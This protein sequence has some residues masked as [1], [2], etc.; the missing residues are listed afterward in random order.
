MISD[1][2]TYL[3]SCYLQ[4]RLFASLLAC[5]YVFLFCWIIA[6]HGY[7][8][9]S[10]FL[11]F[12]V[13]FEDHFVMHHFAFLHKDRLGILVFE[14]SHSVQLVVLV[15]PLPFIVPWI[16]VTIVY[17][18]MSRSV[19]PKVYSLMPDCL[20]FCETLMQPIFLLHLLV[21]VLWTYVPEHDSSFGL[22]QCLNVPERSETKPLA[23]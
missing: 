2:A 1:S 15:F 7:L 17:D 3:C 4:L 10:L 20:F 11:F 12:F 9:A 18:R 23:S 8:F 5:S 13:Y 6:N 22:N 14:F 16:H 19:Y 21:N